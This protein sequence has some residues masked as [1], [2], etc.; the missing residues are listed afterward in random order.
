LSSSHPA[1]NFSIIRKYIETEA[2]NKKEQ[3]ADLEKY[4]DFNVKVR[5]VV[6]AIES[7]NAI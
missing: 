5:T 1:G 2:V 4:N 6:I 7:Y 3:K